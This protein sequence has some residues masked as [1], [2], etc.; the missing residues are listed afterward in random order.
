MTERR[1]PFTDKCKKAAVMYSTALVFSPDLFFAVKYPLCK[2]D[3]D[4]ARECRMAM[5][6][7]TGRVIFPKL[8]DP[9]SSEEVILV[10]G[11][12]PKK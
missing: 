1:D 2:A 12:H 10:R 6:E 5:L 11:Q 8:P 9:P 3:P 7:T 4:Y